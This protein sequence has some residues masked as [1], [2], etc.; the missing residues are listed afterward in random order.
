M[1]SH[2]VVDGGLLQC[3]AQPSELWKGAAGSLCS[4]CDKTRPFTYKARAQG[5]PKAAGLTPQG[6]VQAE[7]QEQSAPLPQRGPDVEGGPGTSSI[8]W[9]PRR[10]Q[11]IL[12]EL[13]QPGCGRAEPEP[14]REDSSL[15]PCCSL[16]QR[17][18]GVIN[19]NRMAPKPSAALT[20]DHRSAGEQQAGCSPITTCYSYKASLCKLISKQIS[21]MDCRKCL[22]TEDSKTSQS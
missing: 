14:G 7:V 11:S 22:S 3:Q 20:L 5:L 10:T 19:D 4:L 15:C 21:L 17:C 9:Q 12:P 8:C 13:G 6:A 1:H 18:W 16:R 2:Q